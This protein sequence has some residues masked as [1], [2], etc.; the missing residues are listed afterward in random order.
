VPFDALVERLMSVEP[1]RKAQRVFPV[2]QTA[3]RTVA[4]NRSG[5]CKAPGRT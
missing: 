4:G 3:P 5:G 2:I 1:Y